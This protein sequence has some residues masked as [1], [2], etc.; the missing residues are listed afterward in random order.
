MPLGLPWEGR[1][2]APTVTAAELTSHFWNSPERKK[3]G[4]QCL[5]DRSLLGAVMTKWLW[6][7]PQERRQLC[8]AHTPGVPGPWEPRGS[9]PVWVNQQDSTSVLPFSNN[10]REKV[11]T[12]DL[13]STPGSRWTWDSSS[14]FSEAVI[15]DCHGVGVERFTLSFFL[16]PR[17]LRSE[18]LV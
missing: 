13:Y 14:F 11:R 3:W 4:E 1:A 15:F 2:V 5:F 16:S 17:C 18:V 7:R 6:I 8:V 10:K 9:E 12:G